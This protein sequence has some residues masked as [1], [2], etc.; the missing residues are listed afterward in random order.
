[1][2]VHIEYFTVMLT[3]IRV[4]FL[5]PNFRINLNWRQPFRLSLEPPQPLQP[6]LWRGETTTSLIQNADVTRDGDTTGDTCR[7]TRRRP[8]AS[9]S[10]Q[11]NLLCHLTTAE[12]K[13]DVSKLWDSWMNETKWMNYKTFSADFTLERLD[14]RIIRGARGRREVGRLTD[15]EP[16]TVLFCWENGSARRNLTAKNSLSPRIR[17]LPWF[18]C[19]RPA[20]KTKLKPSLLY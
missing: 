2:S 6:L 15:P 14:Y 13:D 19:L 11:I 16:R 17:K 4:E 10:D 7:Q 1:M 20:F 12:K 3:T 9:N 18:I 8:H 5:K